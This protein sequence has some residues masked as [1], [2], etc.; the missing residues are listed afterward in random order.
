MTRRFDERFRETD[1]KPLEFEGQLVHQIY[2]R[3]IEPGTLIDVEFLGSRAKPSQGLELKTR[4][5]FLAWD[6]HSVE[7]QS[8]RIWA[9]KQNRAT[10]RYVNPRKTVELAIWNVWLDERTGRHPHEPERYDVVQAWWA[11]SGMLIDEDAGSV[12]LSCTGNCDG[13]DFND[14]AATLTFKTGG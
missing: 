14:L 10:I 8:V 12:R 1:G 5:A 6:E 4:G 3:E 9:D 7:G 2:R 13:P 11:W